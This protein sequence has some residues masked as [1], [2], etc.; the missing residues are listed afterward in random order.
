M[1]KYLLVCL[2]FF[3]HSFASS[4]DTLD[5]KAKNTPYSKAKTKSTL[6]E[7]LT[8][9]L[10]SDKDKARI[11]AAFLVYQM[12]HNLYADVQ[13][14]RASQRIRKAEFNIDTVPFQTRVGRAKDYAELYQE[15]GQMAGLNIVTIY[16]YAGKKVPSGPYLPTNN[17]SDTPVGKIDKRLAY[18]LQQYASAWNAVMIDGEWFLVDTY[19]M[20]KAQKGFGENIRSEVAFFNTLRKRSKG[21][22]TIKSLTKGKSIDEN[23][24]FPRPKDFVATHFPD[25]PQWQL[26]PTPITWS[27]FTY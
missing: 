5:T 15:L 20:D 16:G 4:F 2:L 13:T 12:D 10:K 26:M 19:M 11:L 21:M 1:F 6:V 24:F 23:F 22:P 3:T 7:Y 14:K 9:D 25:E 17:L 8:Q 27:E 18:P